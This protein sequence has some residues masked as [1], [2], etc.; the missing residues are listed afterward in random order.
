MHEAPAVCFPL[1]FL[2][3]I[4]FFVR[5]YTKMILMTVRN[6]PTKVRNFPT[7]VRNFLTKV[8][9]FPMEMKKSERGK[10]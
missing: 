10:R 8:R 9:N 6:F 3:F 1:S 7:K 4:S 2:N 5:G